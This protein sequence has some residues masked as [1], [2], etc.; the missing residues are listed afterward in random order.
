LTFQESIEDAETI[1]VNVLSLAV[2]SRSGAVRLPSTCS[3]ILNCTGFSGFG[4]RERFRI[5]GTCHSSLLN[6]VLFLDTSTTIRLGRFSTRTHQMVHPLTISRH[7]TICYDSSCYHFLATIDIS[8]H[9]VIL[10]EFLIQRNT[11]AFVTVKR[12]ASC[13]CFGLL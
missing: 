2:D 6:V 11:N 5:D 3:V 13:Y 12:K 10:N 8:S 1:E 7:R 9:H 4:C